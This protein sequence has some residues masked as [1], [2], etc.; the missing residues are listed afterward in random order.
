MTVQ[1]LAVV[2]DCLFSK[3]RTVTPLVLFHT[4]DLAFCDARRQSVTGART[5][6]NQQKPP[7]HGLGWSG[8]KAEIG[9]VKG[10]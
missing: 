7:S 8:E 5:G 3:L 10:H 9:S 1:L 2:A 4:T 6:W